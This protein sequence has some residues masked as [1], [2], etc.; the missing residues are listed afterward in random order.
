MLSTAIILLPTVSSDYRLLLL[1]VP[2]ALFLRRGTSTRLAPLIAT[3]FALLLVP[4][5][6]LQVRAPDVNI[7]VVVNPLLLAALM[8]VILGTGIVR[9]RKTRAT[10]D[11]PRASLV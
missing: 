9:Q 11:A 10:S 4:K 2:L 1:V 8:G 7:G 6:Y 5:P 3:C